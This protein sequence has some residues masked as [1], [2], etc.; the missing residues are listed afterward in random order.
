MHAKNSSSDRKPLEHGSSNT[1]GG[2]DDD[3]DDDGD[4]D[5]GDD[6]STSAITTTRGSSRLIHAMI[7][8]MAASLASIDPLIPLL[9]LRL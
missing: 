4:G 5:N 1:I 3:D 2:G 8:A 9:I 6:D 7:V